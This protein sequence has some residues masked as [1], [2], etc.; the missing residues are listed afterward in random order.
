[1]GVELSSADPPPSAPAGWYVN[2]SGSGQRYWDGEQWT[3]SYSGA[4]PPP[5]STVAEDR[6]AGEASGNMGLVIAG[7]ILAVV[8]PLAGFILGIVVATRTQKHVSKHGV[9]IVVVSIV[10]T[11]LYLVA[12]LHSGRGTESASLRL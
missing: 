11:A 12:V 3:D 8:V 9:W 7:Y 4:G 1:V 2:P 5:P 10:V 6:S